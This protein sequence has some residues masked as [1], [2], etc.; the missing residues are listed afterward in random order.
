MLFLGFVVFALCMTTSF[1]IVNLPINLV[2]VHYSFA[3]IFMLMG[4]T[5][6]GLAIIISL[7]YKHPTNNQEENT[8]AQ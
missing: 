5:V 1:S 4:V 8:H 3:A 2:W 6:F 7:A